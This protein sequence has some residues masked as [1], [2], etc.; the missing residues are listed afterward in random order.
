MMC[1][2]MK[3]FHER[4]SETSEH[5]IET[6]ESNYLKI[7]CENH[8]EK[9]VEIYCM[10]DNILICALCGV[11]LH[12][13]HKLKDI[14]EIYLENK[15]IIDELIKKCKNKKEK[16]EKSKKDIEVIKELINYI[17]F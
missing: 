3:E 16:I 13:K 10:D 2:M 12:Q 6:I 4:M 7:R 5:K 15:I 8:K 1:E 9:V 11:I 14:N 17:I